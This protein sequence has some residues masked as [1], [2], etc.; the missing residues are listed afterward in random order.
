MNAGDDSFDF[1]TKEVCAF[2]GRPLS[3]VLARVVVSCLLL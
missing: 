1:M 2:V 3:L